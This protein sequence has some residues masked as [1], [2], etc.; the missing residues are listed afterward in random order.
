MT[1]NATCRNLVLRNIFFSVC[2][3]FFFFVRPI[4]AGESLRILFMTDTH[5]TPGSEHEMAME[6]VVEEIRRD[7]DSYDFAVI[8]GDICN[9]GSDIELKLA[10]EQFD[11][12]GLKYLII[13]GNHETTWS[14]S[15]C[16]TFNKL[17]G[18]DRFE[19]RHGDYFLIGF[20]TG[21]FMKM[22]DGHVKAEDLHWLEQRLAANTKDPKTKVLVFSHYPIR[23]DIGNWPDVV[24]VLKK[25]DAGVV[26]CGHWHR[27]LLLNFGTIPGIMGRPLLFMNGTPPGYNVIEV[28]GDTISVFPRELG[29][30]QGEAFVS[31]K[32]GDPKILDGV[33]S[34]P[35]PDP[36]GGD[37]P[38][39]IR[40][41]LVR[42]DEASVF[43]GPAIQDNTLVYGNSLGIVKV[44]KIAT[45]ADGT[46]KL[47]GNAADSWEVSLGH[48]ASVY[49]TPLI[50]GNR[51]IV[52]STNKEIIGFDL[53]TGTRA[54]TIPASMPVANDGTLAD[55]YLYMGLAKD[56][57]CKIDPKTGRKI[58]SYHGV[59]GRFQGAPTVAHGTV[60]FGAWNQILYAL[61]A[62]TGKE[63]W[64][65]K[66]GRPGNLYSPGNVIPVISDS[67]VVIVAPDRFMTAI[68]RKTGRQIW[69]QEGLKVR[70]STGMSPDGKII[71]AKTMEGHVIA[72]SAISDKFELLWDAETG[73][74]YDHVACPLLFYDG[75]IYYGSPLGVVAAI[76]AE[77][78]KKHW[79]YKSGNSAVNRFSVDD[80]GR[81]WFSLI[82]G[83]I[84][85][86]TSNE[87]K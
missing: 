33:E 39:N 82:E 43:G 32:I 45:D 61:D 10:K 35:L 42:A 58:W 40:I 73:V 87:A 48:T 71:Y 13:P 49:S 55:G 23:S 6:K 37:L 78:G 27:L 18:N 30:P 29:K 46:P 25:Y 53:N 63:L 7:K 34:V 15:A 66:D 80:R 81:V 14:E 36:M 16:Q 67:Q 60:I 8:T 4:D 5:V 11:R 24:A 69:R 76:D 1:T 38:E 65:W 54:W 50:E 70:E 51:L 79:S 64:T 56:E 59:N 28:K 31:F 20:S 84:Y 12:M 2:V 44:S 19:Y 77:T 86:V 22:G 74:T 62:E 75:T 26:F 47:D 3:L 68:D 41:T 85:S 83:K 57:F 9:M 72:V 52:G 17:W 21:P